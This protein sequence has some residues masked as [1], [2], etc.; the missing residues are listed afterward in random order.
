[1]SQVICVDIGNTTFHWA[2]MEDGQVLEHGGWPRRKFEQE[3]RNFLATHKGLPI[4]WCSVSPPAAEIFQSVIW[5]LDV[6][7]ERL[8]CHDAPGLNFDYPNP[9]QVGQDRLA[10]A[11][12][13]QRLVGAP[14]A[15]ID[16]G[17]VTT[18]DLITEKS[19]FIGGVITAGFAMMTQYMHERTAMLPE[20]KE[21]EFDS[22]MNIGRSTVEA[23]SVGWFRGYPGMIRALL[24]GVR[25]EF[26]ALGEPNPTVILTGGAAQGF[27]R[28][29][30]SEFRAEPHLT[31]LG[32]Y[33]AWRRRQLG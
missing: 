24:E 14:A 17:T 11:I 8:S 25:A 31:V 3:A 26:E 6:V 5:D 16:M 22:S 2:L 32:L 4:S 10:N 9:G 33:E 28:E 7:D 1:M 21:S 13:A 20:L 18:F 29:A 30:L 23:M 19:G 27:L 12:G 15:V